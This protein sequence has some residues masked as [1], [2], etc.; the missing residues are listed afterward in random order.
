MEKTII[1]Q[2][3]KQNPTKMKTNSSILIALLLAF[4]IF[5]FYTV[6]SQPISKEQ[7]FFYFVKIYNYSVTTPLKSGG[8]YSQCGGD[9]LTHY[10]YIFDNYNYL[11][12]RNDEFKK[13]EYTKSLTA[14]FQS[15]LS[16]VNFENKFT[17]SSRGSF[18][19]YSFENLSFPIKF[20]EN[21]YQIGYAIPFYEDDCYM[22]INV[23]GIINLAGFNWNLPYPKEKAQSFISKR[24]DA[25]GQINRTIFFKLTYSILNKKSF[26]ANYAHNLNGSNIIIYV[27]SIDIYE[28]ENLNI[29]IGT[30]NS[31]TSY[32]S[33]TED[34]TKEAAIE[35][36][37]VEKVTEFPKAGEGYAT[38]EGLK[39]YLDPLK[40][41]TRVSG[42]VRYTYT[43][44]P[45]ITIT[46]SPGEDG[47]N[48]KKWWAMPAG[49]Y[50]I[51]TE[52]N[53]KV[54]IKWWQ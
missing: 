39:A 11:Q 27:H 41:H 6:K 9:L 12:S 37:E 7:A 18:G 8:G 35:A 54:F 50:F 31:T 5:Q 29:K 22:V 46:E 30:I 45:Q 47:I 14:R 13:H 3:D 26:S 28:D 34:I 42:T 16:K 51:T 48:S 10:A 36:Q 4:F 32:I 43:R 49:Y 25:N 52:K 19:E 2:I 15:E 1:Y 24:K 21:E 23:G 33:V 44:N 20:T 17:V 38:E 40:T 53:N